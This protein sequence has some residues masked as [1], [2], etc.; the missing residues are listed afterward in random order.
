MKSNRPRLGELL[1]KSAVVQTV[2]SMVM[3]LVASTLLDYRSTYS[4]PHRVCW[5]RQFDDPRLLAGPLF[6]PLRGALFGWVFYLLRSVLF[7]EIRG[8]WTMFALIIALGVLNTLGPAPGSI[9]GFV[10]TTIPIRDQLL[11]YLEIVPQALLLAVVL[12]EWVLRPDRRWM[13]W[14]LGTLF[15]FSLIFPV[16]GLLS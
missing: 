6:Q 1:V 8:R 2:S 15:A 4:D 12:H 16:L 3:G 13:D 10:Y 11:G 14:T 5:M 9:E 7:F